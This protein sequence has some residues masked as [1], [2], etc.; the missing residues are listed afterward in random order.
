MRG[1]AGT[2][3]AV[4]LGL[5]LAA[6]W[7][8]LRAQQQGN[9]AGGDAVV[10]APTS[11]PVI[12]REISELWLAPEK[13]HGPRSAALDDFARAVKLE[14]DSDFAK[15]LPILS[16]ASL[17]EGTLGGYAV[18]YE[19]LAELRLNPPEEA[20]RTFQRLEASQPVGYLAQAAALREARSRR[21]AERPG[22]TP[23]R[24]TSG[25]RRRRRSPP[26]TC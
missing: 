17:Q 26:T 5:V 13:A 3:A 9:G 14:V 7:P 23:C 20:R 21:D 22:A 15:A 11:H 2:I 18:Y 6:P 25:S 10:L 1:R 12:P 19:G 24:S 16:R 8:A 4:G